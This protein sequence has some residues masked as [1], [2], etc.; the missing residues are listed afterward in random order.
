MTRVKSIVDIARENGTLLIQESNQWYKTECPRH[1]DIHPTL[2]IDP[3]GEYWICFACKHGGDAAAYVR[4]CNPSISNDAALSEVY[5][6]S[7][8]DWAIL[9]LLEERDNDYEDDERGA[10]LLMKVLKY[11]LID[12]ESIDMLLLS[13]HSTALL[14]GII[15]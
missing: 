12:K 15:G 2:R 4:W 14:E 1:S 5:G 3:A 11:K 7:T 10:L 9:K 6:D 8:V 13:E